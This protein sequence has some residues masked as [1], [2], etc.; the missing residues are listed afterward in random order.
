MILDFSY[1]FFDIMCGH[2]EYLTDIYIPSSIIRESVHPFHFTS[3]LCLG[4]VSVYQLFT[5][6]ILYLDPE[7]LMS[8]ERE[9]VI[10]SSR[11]EDETTNHLF[12][13]RFPY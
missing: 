8:Y 11:E 9:L 2:K 10:Q 3:P 4:R 6:Q 7:S 5:D 1:T 12:E 13:L